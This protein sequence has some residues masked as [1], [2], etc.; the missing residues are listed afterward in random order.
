MTLRDDVP[1]YLQ[2]WRLGAEGERKTHKVLASLGWHVV[3]DVDCGRGNYDHVI[4]GAPGVFLIETKNLTGKVEVRDGEPWLIHRHDPEG[5]RSLQGARTQAWRN[6][7][8][9]RRE[10]EQRCGLRQW[11]DAIVVFWSDFP[12]GIIEADRIAYVHGSKLRDWLVAL[13]ETLDADRLA[14][15]AGALA[16]LKVEGEVRAERRS[17]DKLA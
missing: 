6:S 4:A 5:E 7:A 1:S 11:V 3:E 13:P 9:I 2:S 15:I 12:Q 14:R 8:A 16:G 17:R 10:I